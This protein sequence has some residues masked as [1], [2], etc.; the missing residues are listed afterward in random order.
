MPQC[1]TIMNNDNNHNTIQEFDVN[2]ICDFFLNTNRQGP[3]S[4]EATLKALSF[5]N[6]L[7]VQ[8]LIADLG[9]GTGG[10]T[11]VLAQH[12]PGSITGL[13]FFPEFIECFNRNAEKLNLQDRVKGV[14][15]SMDA[16]SFEKESLDL[17]WSEGAIYNIGFERGINEWRNYLKTGGY[18]AVSES[19]WFTEERPAEIQQFWMDA[20]PEIDTIPNQVAKIQKAGYLPVATFVLPEK[21]WTEHYFLPQIAAREKFLNKYPGDK[22][23]EALIASLQHE[24][25]LY[26]KYKAFYGYVFFIAKKVEG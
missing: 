22:T 18:I 12:T 20:Y 4:P 21:C 15:G 26:R 8:S 9:C 11:M 17:I 13:D 5:I 1:F 14:V 6:N 16:L 10:Q 24:E 25:V 19:S 3:G 7:T 23:A 2:L